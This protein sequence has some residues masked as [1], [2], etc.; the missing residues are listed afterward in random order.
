MINT[1][2]TK[3]MIIN[4]AKNYQFSTRLSVDGKLIE[5]ISQARLLGLVLEDNLSWQANTNHIVRQAYKRMSILQNLYS[6]SVPLQ[7]LVEIYIL[8]IRSVI[9]NSAVV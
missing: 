6:F 2:K 3:Y 9:E 4:F 7:D 5:K 1:D 8:Y